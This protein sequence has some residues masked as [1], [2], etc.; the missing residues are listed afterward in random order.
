[1]SLQQWSGMMIPKAWSGFDFGLGEDV[2]ML[3]KTA[4]D[5]AQDKIA[6]RAEEIDRSN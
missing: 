2:E 4:S 3:R 6:P 1:M 5:F